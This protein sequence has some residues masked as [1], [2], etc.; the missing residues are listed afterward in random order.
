MFNPLIGVSFRC[1]VRYKPKQVLKAFQK[2]LKTLVFNFY[3]RIEIKQNTKQRLF[4]N[5]KAKT[6]VPFH[7]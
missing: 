5:H 4:Q 2:T 1:E 7:S 6:K 3:Q